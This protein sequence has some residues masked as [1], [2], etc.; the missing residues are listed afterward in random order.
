MNYSEKVEE[1]V[2]YADLGNKIQSCM[3]YLA[4]EI[5]AV[6][7]T[8]EWAIKNNEFRL[9]QEI[10]NAWKSH[11]VALSILKSIRED[12]ERMNDEIVMLVKREQEKSATDECLATES[13]NA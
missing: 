10:N 11:Y 5:E 2:E 12:N 1:T 9:Q 8:R 6:E 7:Q 3:D 4:T 13:D